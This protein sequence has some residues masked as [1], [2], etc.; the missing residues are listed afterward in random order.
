MTMDNMAQLADSF[1][2]ATNGAASR[3]DALLFL[4][5]R[6]MDVQAAAALYTV[7]KHFSTDMT[8][9]YTANPPFPFAALEE[10]VFSFT[11]ETATDLVGTPLLFVN[12]KHWHKDWVVDV[13]KG[14]I[15]P[16]ALRAFQW[17]LF[18][19]I[20]KALYV[21]AVRKQGLTLFSNTAGVDPSLSIHNIHMMLVDFIRNVV[22]VKLRTLIVCD[23]RPQSYFGMAWA[24]VSPSSQLL[25]SLGVEIIE[26]N[27]RTVMSYVD[28]YSL[29][30]EM[31]GKLVYDHEQW[32]K[33]Q[34]AHF[35]KAKGVAPAEQQQPSAAAPQSVTNSK[36]TVQATRVYQHTR[37]AAASSAAASSKAAPEPAVIPSYEAISAAIIEDYKDRL[38]M[39]VTIAGKPMDELERIMARSEA[40]EDARQRFGEKTNASVQSVALLESVLIDAEKESDKTYYDNVFHNVS[41]SVG[42]A[43][44]QWEADIQSGRLST[45]S[46]LRIEVF[47][48]LGSLKPESI[49]KNVWD[50][51][52]SAV[53][54][55]IEPLYRSLE[56]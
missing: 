2:A 32:Y 33:T 43:K 17:A 55:E 26:C 41:Q 23:D 8:D 53:Q 36:P 27:P 45:V 54:K 37:P 9:Y 25:K 4:E 40:L 7:H 39:H 3:Q 47:S 48:L 50:T 31:D 34:L 13:S 24:Y 52:E 44:K 12:L 51:V 56:R 35:K 21:P 49:V 11:V 30:V 42:R 20:S 5:A 22:P 15:D 6:D 29:P 46:Q 14:V 19:I 1:I 18:W 38:L 10:N 16:D 28:S